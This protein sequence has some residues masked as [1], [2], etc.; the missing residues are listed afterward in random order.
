MTNES[1]TE[2]AQLRQYFLNQRQQ[3]LPQQWQQQSQQLCDQLSQWDLFRQA[4]TVCA[5]FSHRQEVDLSGLFALPKIWGFPRCVQKQLIWSTWQPNDPLMPDQYGI[6]TPVSTAPL[7]EPNQVDLI[8]VPTLA[9]DRR[10]YRLGY[11]GGYYDRLF[12]QPDW[13]AVPKVGIVFATAIIDQLPVDAWDLPLSGFC[14]EQ[15][16][17]LRENEQKKSPDLGGNSNGL[18]LI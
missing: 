13:Q 18:R 7:L 8:L 12:A 6:L 3:L 14:S 15:G 16:Y 5:Y 10:G 2:K 4:E 1:K 11:G 9:G 17:F